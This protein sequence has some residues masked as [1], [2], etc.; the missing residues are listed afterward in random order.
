[1]WWWWAS[2]LDAKERAE[3]DEF[4]EGPSVG[5]VNLR[6]SKRMMKPG[7]LKYLSDKLTK[8]ERRRSGRP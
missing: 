4:W 5:G 6:F 2:W 7:R 8:S 1:M 3:G